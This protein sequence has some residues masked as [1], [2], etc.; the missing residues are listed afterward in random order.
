M[1]KLS[2]LRLSPCASPTAPR[3]CRVQT[4]LL[5]MQTRDLL[6]LARS[7]AS[8]GHPV[9]SVVPVEMPASV[10]AKLKSTNGIQLAP[11]VAGKTSK[12]QLHL[13]LSKSLYRMGL[14][15]DVR[16]QVAGYV[17]DV[18]FPGNDLFGAVG[19]HF[20]VCYGTRRV[21]LCVIFGSPLSPS[22]PLLSPTMQTSRSRL[23]CVPPGK[24]PS[25]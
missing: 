12:S 16:S 15:H 23:T 18:S 8:S 17:V 25:C 21:D 6:M 13:G 10:V 20:L 22:P 5:L 2:V 1:A 9:L 4:A 19:Y 11:A 14:P 7:K 24:M 3:M